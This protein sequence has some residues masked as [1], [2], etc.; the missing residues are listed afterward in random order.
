[1]IELPRGSPEGQQAPIAILPSGQQVSLAGTSSA[2]GPTTAGGAGSAGPKTVKQLIQEQCGLELGEPTGAS[3]DKQGDDQRFS[4]Y[5]YF[6]QK[7][8]AG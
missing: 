4:K 7:L 1:M 6:I 2:A 8:E 3:S 5:E